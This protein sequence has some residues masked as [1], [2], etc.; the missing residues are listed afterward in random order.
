M[1]T[2]PLRPTFTAKNSQGDWKATT[3]F[4]LKSNFRLKIVT[5][6]GAHGLTTRAT[7]HAVENGME[8]HR[9]YKDYSVVLKV[10]SP[11]RVTAKVVET[12]HA[13]VLRMSESVIAAAQQFYAELE[14]K[15]AQVAQVQEA[16][17]PS[18]T[19]FKD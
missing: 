19:A 9:L 16:T 18:S 13:E 14:A 8:V 10:S 6:K 7:A 15:D 12:Q 1:P 17:P 2:T 3:E 4:M 5:S 11:A